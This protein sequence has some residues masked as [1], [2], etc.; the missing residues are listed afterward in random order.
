MA[1]LA[2]ATQWRVVAGATGFI[3]TGLDYAAARAGMEGDG[4]EVTP[5]LWGDVRII[6]AGALQEFNRTR[7]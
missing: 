1:F 2:V 6:E 3:V 4:I 7:P 5:R